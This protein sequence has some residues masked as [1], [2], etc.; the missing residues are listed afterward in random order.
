M[1]PWFFKVTM[2]QKEFVNRLNQHDKPVIIDLWAPWCAPCRAM[3]PA[4]KQIS[5]KYQGEV[6]VWKINADES[7]D[8][9]KV[10]KVM[11]IPTVIGFAQGKEI[12]RRSGI[13][14]LEVLDILFDATLHQRKPDIIPPAPVERFLRSTA[15]IVLMTLGWINNQ[16]WL[17]LGIGA[18]L[19]FSAFYDRCPVYRAIIPRLRQMFSKSPSPLNE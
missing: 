4:F 10:L 11:G 5:E 12:V 16:S 1:R 17:L 15:G 6:D 13:Q 7:P 8:V 9:L 18:V 14:S 2:N 19:L 3:E